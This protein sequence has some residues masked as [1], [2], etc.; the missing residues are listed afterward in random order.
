MPTNCPNGQAP[1]RANNPELRKNLGLWTSNGAIAGTLV[2]LWA[3]SHL[4]GAGEV[5]DAAVVSWRVYKAVQTAQ[6]TGRIF[7]AVEAN[8]G[9]YMA[10]AIGGA[11]A[12]GAPG[13]VIGFAV[14]PALCP[15]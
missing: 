12:G 15:P 8:G 3:V 11:A 9:A 7:I 10:G 2:G 5:V 14:T 1:S 13:D 4:V 6:M